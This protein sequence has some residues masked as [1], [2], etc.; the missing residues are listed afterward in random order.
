M[1]AVIALASNLLT[2]CVKAQ[3]EKKDKPKRR[4]KIEI[5]WYDGTKTNVPVLACEEKPSAKKEGPCNETTTNRSG[6]DVHG[7]CTV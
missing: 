1:E 6:P 2:C 5:D 7:C 4:I 3:E